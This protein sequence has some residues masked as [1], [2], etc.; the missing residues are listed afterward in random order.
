M[1]NQSNKNELA[2]L[3][4]QTSQL[5][6]SVVDLNV[7]LDDLQKKQ[8]ELTTGWT[9]LSTQFKDS[10][11]NITATTAALKALTDQAGEQAKALDNSKTSLQQN[12]DL[13]AALIQ[14]YAG[15]S[16]SQSD[17]SKNSKDL[18][19]QITGLSS[20]ID[21]QQKKLA[22]S[23]EAFDFHAESTKALN[24]TLDTLKKSNKDFGPVLEDVTK[25]FN[26]MKTGLSVVKTGF[27]SMGGAIKAAGFGLLILALQ[28]L[29][30]YFTKN[31]QGIKVFKGIIASVGLVIETIKKQFAKFTEGIIDAISHPAETFKKIWNAV[32]ENV[33]NRFKGISVFFEGLFSGNLKKMGDGVIQMTTGVTN[34][35]D[36]IK[37]AY[38]GAKKL[39]IEGAKVIAK[40]YEEA[41][42]AHKKVIDTLKK[43]HAV[44]QKL[45]KELTDAEKE[46]AARLAQ[47]ANEVK[48]AD[49]D[50]LKSIAR[51]AA[52]KLSAFAKEIEDTQAHYT[53]MLAKYDDYIKDYE[54]RS[55][56][57]E[58]YKKAH[59][60]DYEAATAAVVQLKKEENDALLKLSDKYRQQDLKQLDDYQDQLKKLSKASASE[61]IEIAIKQVT[62]EQNIK[63]TFITKSAAE[64]KN[65]LALLQEYKNTANNLSKDE[66]IAL[67]NKIDTEIKIQTEGDTIKKQLAVQL[68][69]DIARIKADAA[70]K[71]QEDKLN[72]GI[73]HNEKTGH[74][75]KALQ[76]QK[77][78]LDLQYKVALAAATK[79]GKD[80]TAIVDDYA[81]KKADIE[82]QLTES[83]I[84]AG[85]TFINAVL[86]NTKKDSALYK[87]AFLA[88]KATTIADTI[89]S[90][91]Q[92]VMDSL[93]A[94][95]GI[96]FIGQALGIAQAA[97]MAVQGAT[98]IAEIAKQKPGFAAGG[99]F[100]SDGRGALLPGYS[101]TDN[102]NAY[103]RS[104]EAVVVSEAMRNPWARNLVS[105]INVA[106]GGRDFSMANA[107]RGYAVGGIF[108]DGGNANR[109]Y[110]QPAHDVKDLANTLAYQMINNFP[111]IY[112]DVKDVNNQQNIL[113]QTVN[114]VNL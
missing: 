95:S 11:V 74:L 66:L 79:E 86:V 13:L 20:A 9:K 35:I 19:A 49:D 32:I 43:H 12:K 22:K 67:N 72:I 109:Y 68:E 61:A 2:D 27:S 103:L 77:T 30:E 71:E 37:S 28:T 17:S 52:V 63:Q 8:E 1:D 41:G 57:D 26:G 4:A 47:L 36:K 98:S 91:K 105:A 18:V 113:A 6:K 44:V 25:G 94:Y 73:Q 92:A 65:R 83:K 15:L 46:K 88:K 89:M 108:T 51:M 54:V 3:A 90:T 102:T 7:V 34:G 24:G 53:Q 87:A 97:F 106:H 96:P 16:N 70:E 62:D 23:K 85:D 33:S 38:A 39:I 14:Q 100:I 75:T 59:Q 64:S 104:G 56:T 82:H 60:K 114:R 31:T 80:T 40:T 93:K 50:R 45:N 107:G 29:I 10:T 48:N 69:V 76:D 112:V 42:K 58:A 81:K 21:D 99:Q 110:N 111:P 84:H 78:L 5:K 55:K 101:R